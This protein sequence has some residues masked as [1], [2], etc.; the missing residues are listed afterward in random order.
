MLNFLQD[1]NAPVY[2]GPA[3][4]LQDHRKLLGIS[5]LMMR[6][7]QVQVD[8]AI[9]IAGRC[10]PMLTFSPAMRARYTNIAERERVLERFT[11]VCER[12]HNCACGPLPMNALRLYV[13]LCVSAARRGHFHPHLKEPVTGWIAL[14][15]EDLHRVVAAELVLE[16]KPRKEGQVTVKHIEAM[17]RVIWGTM[18]QNDDGGPCWKKK[19]RKQRSD[20]KPVVHA[21]QRIELQAVERVD[22]QDLCNNVILFSST[23]KPDLI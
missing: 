19:R 2:V 8:R 7:L 23:I 13:M 22:L 14:A 11:S 20:K 18:L 10:Q 15:A 1:Q 21:V 12:H 17:L 9:G 6:N 16:Q 4:A 3:D 5:D